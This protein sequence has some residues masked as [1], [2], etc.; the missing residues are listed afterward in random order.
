MVTTHHA[1]VDVRVVLTP[2]ELDDATTGWTFVVVDVLRATSVVVTALANGARA[3]IPVS[4]IERARELAARDGEA[5]LG[6]ERENARI[7]G[8]DCGNSPAEYTAERV[9][10]RTVVLTTTNGTRAFE[11]AALHAGHAPVYSGALLNLEA[12]TEAALQTE[13]SI[14]V[15]CAA[16]VGEVS[17]EDTTCAGL[18]ALAAVERGATP[19]DDV[20]S[21]AM[22]AAAHARGD[23]AARATAGTHARHL[24]EQGFAH[25]VRSC[26]RTGVFAIAP[27][28]RDGV[29][30]IEA[31]QTVS[32][33]GLRAV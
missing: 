31:K 9:A 7:E 22:F 27:R 21:V 13:R 23:L 29:I 4:S 32:S 15:L 19:V 26:A 20:T 14:A 30:R 28:M 10:G 8:F 16:H 1:P 5:V 3:V 18:I 17:L 2:A 12:V 11:Y 25:D 6:G 33:S 24:V